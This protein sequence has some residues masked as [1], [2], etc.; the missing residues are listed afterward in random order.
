MWLPFSTAR[1]FGGHTGY[2]VSFVLDTFL[3]MAFEMP[4]TAPPCHLSLCSLVMAYYQ[5]ENTVRNPL[6]L[7]EN[8]RPGWRNMV[9]WGGVVRWEPWESND[10]WREGIK[11]S[12]RRAMQI[13][14]YN[15]GSQTLSTQNLSLLASSWI[16]QTPF[17]F[18]TYWV[19]SFTSLRECLSA[20][21]LVLDLHSVILHSSP[22]LPS[23]TPP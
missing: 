6:S 11:G 19:S 3:V 13:F 14:V 10:P 8:K 2:S 18:I 16:L 4:C 9:S 1:S 17:R 15:S 21:V 5:E 22:T 23:L 20:F 12:C 7:K